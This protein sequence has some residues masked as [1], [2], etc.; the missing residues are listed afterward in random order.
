[1]HKEEDSYAPLLPDMPTVPSTA[2]PPLTAP[3]G[4]KGIAEVK[5]K[6]IVVKRRPGATPPSPSTHPSKPGKFLFKMILAGD[7]GVGKTALRE[8]YLG[9]GF[10]S[11]YLQTI[12]ADFATTEKELTVDGQ[13]RNVQYQI[14]DLAGQQEFQG[15]RG[16]YYEGCFGAFMVFDITRPASFENIPKWINELWTNSGRGVVPIILLGNKADLR[17]QF[18]EAV[19]DETIRAYVN[20]VNLKCRPFNFECEYLETSAKT[21]LNVDN[22]FSALGIN[23]VKWILAAKR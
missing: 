21:G 6:T 11:S 17:N 16:T 15:I 23:V 2:R 14:W 3:L 22:A 13:Q 12:G 5:K 8:R 20:Q 10:S 18:P 19:K 1:M 4:T 9:R 7:G